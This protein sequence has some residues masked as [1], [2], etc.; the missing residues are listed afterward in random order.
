M[1]YAD[2]NPQNTDLEYKIKTLKAK[3][4]KDKE[5]AVI[6]SALF[7]MNKNEIYKKSIYM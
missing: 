3:G 4:F 5:V 7:D 1:I 2:E 6:L